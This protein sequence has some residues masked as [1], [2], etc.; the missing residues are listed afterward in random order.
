MSTVLT[1][2][3]ASPPARS[4]DR[5]P[6][7]RLLWLIGRPSASNRAAL[8][9]P[10]V[11]FGVATALLLL[12]VAGT[13]LFVSWADDPLYPALGVFACVLLLVPLVSLS[14]IAA[15]LSA[16]RRDDRLATLRL[17]GA[18]SRT[19][20]TLTLVESTTL[21]VIGAG[22]GILLYAM[23]V[24]VVG[25]VPFRGAPIGTGALWLHPAVIALVVVGVGAIAAVSATIGLRRV[26]ITPLGVRARESAPRL[27]WSRPII[28][29]A[30]IAGAVVALSSLSLG[31]GVAVVV[32]VLCAAFFGVLAVLNLVGPWALGV[33]ARVQVR[34]ARTAP[35]LIAARAV[36]ENPKAAWRQVSGVAMT[37][38]VAVVG[39]GGIAVTDAVGP[40]VD[41]VMG[42]IRT[43]V[44]LTL[45]I[46]FAMVAC[47]VG[48]AQAAQILDR[49][50]LW[51]A[52]DR[53]GMPV[54]VMH[55][56]RRRE[57]LLPLV[58][59]VVTAAAAG[60]LLVFPLLGAALLFAPLTVL[61]VALSLAAGVALVVGAVVASSPVLTRVL[62]E[63]ARG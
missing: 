45:A 30:I 14:G 59:T 36:L 48:V 15:R 61:V 1:P 53:A 5:T 13:A 25:L 37:T 52:L 49:R 20:V 31:A 40:D 58:F 60:G 11:A 22:A 47:A 26:R 10:V 54:S 63:P 4:A 2:S 51:V 50:E 8:V 17:L 6:V 35:R 24:P 3:A 19:V 43:G 18:S 32:T 55:A 28:A 42:D 39:G 12:V 33:L 16:R 7:L 21:A 56:A 57:V 29:V 44:L 34:R 46:S 9:L 62:A 41:P 38:F 23:L 27:H